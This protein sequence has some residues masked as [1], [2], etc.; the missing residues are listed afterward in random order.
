MSDKNKVT[1]SV[2]IT[3]ALR[4]KLYRIAEKSDMSASQVVRY[5]IRICDEDDL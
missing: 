4:A 5:L 2:N 1:I 3:E